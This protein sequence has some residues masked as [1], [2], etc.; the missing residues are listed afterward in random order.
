MNWYTALPDLTGSLEVLDPALTILISYQL[1]HGRLLEHNRQKV[2]GCE[3]FVLEGLFIFEPF[4]SKPNV[5]AFIDADTPAVIEMDLLGVEVAR[6]DFSGSS[7]VAIGFEHV[8]FQ[9]GLR[10]LLTEIK[11]ILRLRQ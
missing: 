8:P 11:R 1:H 5:F 4:H 3:N 7:R 6:N 2:V 9:S 10:H